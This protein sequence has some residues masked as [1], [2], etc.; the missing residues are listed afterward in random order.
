MQSSKIAI[1]QGHP[2]QSN[3]HYCHA[4]AKAYSEG[5]ITKNHTVT[6]IDAS[7]LTLPFLRNQE[8][9]ESD[10]IDESVLNIQN[11]ITNA[12][13]IVIIYP[14][15]LGIMPASLKHFFEQ[16]IRP[17]FAFKKEKNKSI[18]KKLLKGKSARIIVTMGMPSIIYQWLYHAHSLKSFEQ[19]ILRFVGFSP[20]HHTIIGRI[21][22]ISDKRRLQWLKRIKRLGENSI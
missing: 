20:I 13:H 7:S 21:D 17:S 9:F 1:I 12:D 22:S 16:V 2:D 3:S 4:I 11:I 5:A 8:E 6:I 10:T 14:L 15:W 18:P 19:L